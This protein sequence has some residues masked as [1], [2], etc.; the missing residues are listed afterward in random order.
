VVAQ[1]RASPAWLAG[2]RMKRRAR[3]RALRLWR[4]MGLR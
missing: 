2:R 1:V 4:Q 3:V